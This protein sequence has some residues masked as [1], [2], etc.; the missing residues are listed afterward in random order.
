MSC[1]HH[2]YA[3]WLSPEA[4]G[5]C[6]CHG[7]VRS[8][9]GSASLLLRIRHRWKACCNPRLK[10]T[11]KLVSNATKHLTTVWTVV[12]FFFQNHLVFV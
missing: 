11:V 7:A 6:S 1:L 4:P 5:Q 3:H 12:V 2:S 8:R 10:Q 9:V